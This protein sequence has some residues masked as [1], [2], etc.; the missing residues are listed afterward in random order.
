MMKK[1]TLSW[2]L[3]GTARINRA[4]IPPLKSSKRNRLL[5]V[6]SRDAQ[7]AQQYAQEWDI[8]RSHGSYE[9]LLADPDIDVIYNSLPNHLHKEWTIRAVQAGKHVLCEKPLALSAADVDEMIAASRQ[10]GRVIAE[11]FMYR[12]HP[13]THHIKEMIERGDLG[14]LRLVRGAFS[15]NFD[16]AENYRLDPT[17]GG[18]SLWDV[19]CYPVSFA[20]Y[21]IGAEPL[22]VFGWQKTGAS[23]V[24][25]VF[26]AQMRF[27]GEIFAQF[28]SSFQYVFRMQVEIVGSQA[29]LQVLNPFKPGKLSLALCSRGGMFKPLIIP[30]DT[31]YQGEI[32]DIANVVLDG[33]P[34]RIPLEHS[35]GNIAVLIAL[36]ESARQGKPQ[37]M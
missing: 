7:R 16:R 26:V 9:A 28:D 24:D 35:R 34:Q 15:F 27:P 33:K 13:Q 29:T 1:T 2:G 6:A 30:G 20:R 11:A 36:L 8:P 19:G 10:T 17:M 14:E 21:L 37:E 31:L 12:H 5:A 32:E 3:L 23:G 22:E 4:V 25:E 18:G